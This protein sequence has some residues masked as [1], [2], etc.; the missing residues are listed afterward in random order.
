MKWDAPDMTGK[1]VP[2]RMECIEQDDA[3]TM[4]FFADGQKSMM[5][6]MKRKGAKPAGGA[7]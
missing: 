6:A 4:T 5:I 2:H 1:V 7:R 3:Y